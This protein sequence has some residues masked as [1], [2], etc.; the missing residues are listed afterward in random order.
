VPPHTCGL[1]RSRPEDVT[2]PPPDF[3][4]L[5][6]SL[7]PPCSFLFSRLGVSSGW[8]GH[9]SSEHSGLQSLPSVLS[10]QVSY[11]PPPH[12]QHSQDFSFLPMLVSPILL[13]PPQTPVSRPY[14]VT[15]HCLRVSTSVV[16]PSQFSVKRLPDLPARGPFLYLPAASLEEQKAPV[17][18]YIFS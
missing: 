18:Q 12:P 7:P 11:F 1:K 8:I 2:A 9:G 3:F 15:M 10:A 5:L 16:R 14:R 17:R 4:Y 6:I 13:P